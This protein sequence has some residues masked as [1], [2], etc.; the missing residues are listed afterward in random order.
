[1]FPRVSLYVSQR[2]GLI[3][4]P[5]PI[6]N[7]IIPLTAVCDWFGWRRVF[8]AHMGQASLQTLGSMRTRPN[9]CS[10]GLGE[11]PSWAKTRL[12][13]PQT[14]PP[15][16]LHQQ[17]GHPITG[18]EEGCVGFFFYFFIQEVPLCSPKHDLSLWSPHWPETIV[19]RPVSA[20]GQ[21]IYE[22][23][24]GCVCVCECVQRAIP[25][26]GTL[27]M[28]SYLAGLDP[29]WEEVPVIVFNE[30]TSQLHWAGPIFWSHRW[31]LIS[32]L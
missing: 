3:D 7:H 20:R 6:L 24:R 28:K 11:S 18:R 13:L 31:L 8:W 30:S 22:R 12:T 1:M 9:H 19:W 16:Y 32:E 2:Q 4:I 17:T 15:G 27:A 5:H 14:R 25:F 23:L 21:C 10:A 29:W 26:H